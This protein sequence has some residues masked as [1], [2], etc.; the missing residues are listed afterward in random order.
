MF[1]ETLILWYV[2]SIVEVLVQ[3]SPLLILQLSRL[4]PPLLDEN[5]K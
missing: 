5:P 4:P 1:V 2:V 3:S